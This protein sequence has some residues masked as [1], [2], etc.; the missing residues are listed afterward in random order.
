[1]MR[2]MRCKIRLARHWLMRCMSSFDNTAVDLEATVLE[3]ELSIHLQLL[4]Q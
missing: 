1:M 2:S 3:N 4:T